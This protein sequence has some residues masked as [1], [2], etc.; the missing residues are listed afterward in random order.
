[1]EKLKILVER[2]K[3]RDHEAFRE[4]FEV[5]EPRVFSY[6]CSHVERREDA[7]DIT[8]E[9]FIDLW[10][11]LKK[12]SYRTPE[13]FYG[14]MFLIAKKKIARFYKSKK[15]D[16]SLEGSEIDEGFTE[17]HE[18]HRFLL[19]HIGTLSEKYQEILRLRYWSGMK[20]AEAAKILGID[21]GTA[22]VRHHRALAMLRTR[23]ENR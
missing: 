23:M 17:E 4:I 10:K 6:A 7:M 11:A 13:E 21:E 19:R 20:L 18:D 16:V 12:F 9:T 8:Q 1:M 2:S 14:F 22:K 15:N 3:D 5:L